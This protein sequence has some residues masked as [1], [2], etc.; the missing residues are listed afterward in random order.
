[1]VLPGCYGISR[2]Q[3]ITGDLIRHAAGPRPGHAFIYIGNGRIVEVAPPTVRIAPAASHPD[4]LWNAHCSLTA[5]QRQRICVRALALVGR[6]YDYPA[7]TAFAEGS[8]RAT[9]SNSIGLQGRSLAGVPAT[10]C[11]AYLRI[12]WSGSQPVGAASCGHLPAC[13]RLRPA[14][15]AHAGRGHRDSAAGGD[16]MAVLGIVGGELALHRRGGEGRGGARCLRD[17]AGRAVAAWSG[18]RSRDAL[19]T[20]RGSSSAGIPGRTEGAVRRAGRNIHR[21]AIPATPRGLRIVPDG[22]FSR[23]TSAQ[24]GL[25]VAGPR[26]P[27]IR[28]RSFLRCCRVHG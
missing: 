28:F 21:R 23:W 2:G 10:G 15:A 20:G 6:P 22:S 27:T 16:R 12:A 26:P 11:Y 19:A 18:S 9:A 24:P 7:Y 3:G 14:P 5:V 25:I 1:M 8:G 4:A 13:V 17:P